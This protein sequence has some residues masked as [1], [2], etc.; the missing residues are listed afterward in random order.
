MVKVLELG[1]SVEKA[2]PVSDKNLLFVSGADGVVSSYTVET[3]QNQTVIP[4]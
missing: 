3:L 1:V 2:I 4:H